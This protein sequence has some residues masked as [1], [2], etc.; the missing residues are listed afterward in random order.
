MPPHADAQAVDC[1][2]KEHYVPRCGVGNGTPG[3]GQNSLLDWN[4]GHR[5]KGLE[6]QNFP[7]TSSPTLPGYMLDSHL[8]HDAYGL[9]HTLFDV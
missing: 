9:N 7:T 3:V 2:S 6:F 4:F 5:H 8:P 1:T